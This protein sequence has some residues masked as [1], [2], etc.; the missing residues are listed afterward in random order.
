MSVS[1]SLSYFDN[2]KLNELL[3]LWCKSDSHSAKISYDQFTEYII[4]GTQIGNKIM[5]SEIS[6]TFTKKCDIYDF[7]FISHRNKF[8]HDV[9]GLCMIK[10]LND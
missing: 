1:V 7:I 9:L 10:D 5:A 3:N 6:T 4:V 8:N 2:N